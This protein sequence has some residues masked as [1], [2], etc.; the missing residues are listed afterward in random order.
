[1]ERTCESDVI[2][3]RLEFTG[4][5]PLPQPDYVYRDQPIMVGT[6]ELYMGDRY[7]VESVNEDET[8]PVAVLRKVRR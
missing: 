4:V 2:R 7:L 5:A 3:Y 6:V 8:P 1:M